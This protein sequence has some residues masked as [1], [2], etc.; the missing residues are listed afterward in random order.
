M[1]PSVPDKAEQDKQNEKDDKLNKSMEVLLA[2][3]HEGDKEEQ[4]EE[5][6]QANHDLINQNEALR[7]EL[8]D[9]ELQL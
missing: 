2:N 8:A 6:I 5:L 1:K 7:K 3:Y 4:M 9:M